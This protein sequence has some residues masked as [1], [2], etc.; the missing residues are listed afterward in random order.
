MLAAVGPASA[1]VRSA[2]AMLRDHVCAKPAACELGDRRAIDALIA[3]HGVVADVT[4]RVLWV[5]AGPHLSGR[6][7]RLDL[8]ALLRADASPPDEGTLETLP[9]D[10]TAPEARP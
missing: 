8:R 6:F 9:G 5:S 4:D 2:V 10:A 3:T 7:V 1:D